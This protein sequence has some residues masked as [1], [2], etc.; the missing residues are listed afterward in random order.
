MQNQNETTPSPWIRRTAAMFVAVV[1]AIVWTHA[2]AGVARSAV[3]L[4]PDALAPVASLLTIGAAIAAAVASLGAPSRRRTAGLGAFAGAVA[5]L[6]IALAHPGVLIPALALVPATIGA[7]LAGAA[8]GRRLP[9]AAER[10]ADEHRGLAAA[11]V[12]VALLAVVQVGRLSTYMSD[13]TSDWFLS[14]RHPFYAKHECLN[15]YVFA[16]ELNRRGEPNVYR[17]E[18][19]PGL[20]PEAKPETAM[21]GLTPEDPYQYVPQFLLLPRFAIALTGDHV[22]IR[23]LW[24]GLNVTL[25]IG[26]VLAL[27]G[28]V[29]GRRGLVAGL[30]TPL[31]LVAFPVLHNFQYGQ[32]H[33]AAIALAVLALILIA[34]GRAAVGGTALALAILSKLFPA[35]LLVPLALQ[36]RWR[37]L[38]WT[39]G[40]S[41]A[42]TALALVTLGTDVFT[43]FVDY[44]LPRLLDGRAFAFGDAWPE[45]AGLVTAG[46]QGAHGIVHKLVA[47]GVPGVDASMTRIVGAIAN[48]G[49][50]AAAVAIG[51]RAGDR[52][53]A[54]RATAWL[55]LLGLASLTSPGAWADYVPLTCVWALVWILPIARRRPIAMPLAVAC[56][57]LQ[58]TLLGTMPLGSWINPRFML[59][60]SLLGSLAM[61]ATFTTAVVVAVRRAP[62]RE[63]R[64][65][66]D[67]LPEPRTAISGA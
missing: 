1:A 43:A 41:A 19:Y 26:A 62:N 42:L 33:F 39:F 13:P 35:I 52:G 6:A 14:T 63:A 45:L 9:D 53:R 23:L 17:A 15:A 44:H 10:L 22:A 37:A 59:T 34:R 21:R 64:R 27:A 18:H 11:W 25:C 24:F 36:R 54:E 3:G 49:V 40:A 4:A 30:S 48:L 66:S 50:L 58:T 29:G 38:G 61:F 57:V 60:V 51:L 2:L 31:V 47:L 32:F 56:L 8:V 16:A 12:A 55:G 65:A 20:N 46:N 7:A 67:A 28:W 5:L